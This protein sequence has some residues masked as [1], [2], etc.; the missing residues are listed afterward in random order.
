MAKSLVVGPAPG[1]VSELDISG[2]RE[3][4]YQ[5]FGVRGAELYVITTHELT[6]AENPELISEFQSFRHEKTWHGKVRHS[7]ESKYMGRQGK[8]RHDMAWKGKARHGKT[9]QGKA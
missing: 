1:T 8:E 7:M 6:K 3:T 4:E 2:F 9:R 5:D